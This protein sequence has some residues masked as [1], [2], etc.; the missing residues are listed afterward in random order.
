MSV[1]VA[2]I[3]IYSGQLKKA[4]RG[5]GIVEGKYTVVRDE[6]ETLNKTTMV[7][8]NLVTSADVTLG[9]KEAILTKEGKTCVGTH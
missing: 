8:W 7:R 9:N 3:S 6:V 5:A 2:S 4:K 1:T